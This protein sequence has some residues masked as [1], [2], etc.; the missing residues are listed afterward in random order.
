MKTKEELQEV[1]EETLRCI[2]DGGYHDSTGKW[3]EFTDPLI[4][5][6]FYNT[7]PNTSK[8]EKKLYKDT[9]IYVQNIDTFL[10]AKEM[11]PRCAVL[12]MASFIRPGGGV[13]NGSRA[14]EEELFRRSNLARSL[15]N[16]HDTG[17]EI[18]GITTKTKPRYPIPMYG[19]IYSPN[20]TVF[21]SNISYSKIPNPF[22]CSV[23]SVSAIKRPTV[24]KDG[25]LTERDAV[26]TRGKIRA[27]LR[28]A[29][30]HGHSK[31]V[32]GA[33][34]CGAYGNPPKHVAKLFH[35]VLREKEF[36]GNFEEICFAILEDA[37]SL[38]NREK[39]NIK[40]FKEVFK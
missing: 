26:V 19:G 25:E 1:Y 13:L 37:N 12:N 23:I 8:R 24:G 32:L 39:G 3:H 10:K 22:R 9:K 6:K 35:E 28:I 34:G 7:L 31:L 2:F 30:L 38:N 15:Y 11:G 16:F 17:R 36:R 40:P 4:G 27:I 18:L 21:K 14:Q 5:S 33:F 29:I 20:V